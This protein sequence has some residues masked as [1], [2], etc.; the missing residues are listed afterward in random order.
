M[1]LLHLKHRGE[2]HTPSSLLSALAIITRKAE[3]PDRQSRRKKGPDNPQGNGGELDYTESKE[4][5]F[6]K[7]GLKVP[8]PLI[9]NHFFFSD[10]SSFLFSPSREELRRRRKQSGLHNH[11]QHQGNPTNKGGWDAK[12]KLSRNIV[13]PSKGLCLCWALFGPNFAL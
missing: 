8:P 3:L 1:S 9:T 6:Q 13:T 11:H 2:K 7:I 10:S 5:C 4:R 12:W